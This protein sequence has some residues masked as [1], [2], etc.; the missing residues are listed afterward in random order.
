[1]GEPVQTAE[2]E[3]EQEAQTA[4]TAEQPA[5]EAEAAVDQQA[6]QEPEPQDVVFTLPG[7]KK[8]TKAELI[9][10]EKLLSNLVTHSNQL[11]NFQ[12]LA[13]ERKAKLEQVEA[14]NRRVL[15]EYTRWQMQQQAQQQAQQMQQ[16][17]PQRPPAQVI[18]G[19]FAPVLDQ[20]VQDGRLSQDHRTEFGPLIA[21]YLFDHQNLRNMVA[22]VIQAGQQEFQNLRQTLDGDV[23]PNVQQFRVQQATA[24]DQQV[25]QE[26]AT[27]PGYEGLAD[28]N[29]WNRLKAFISEKVNASPRLENGRPSFDPQFDPITMA[30][31]YDA[32]T[33]A[34]L[35]QQIATEKARQQQASQQT[36]SMVGGEAA[37][38][39]GGPVPKKPG[40]LTPEE[41][42]MDFGSPNMMTG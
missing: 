36:R 31:M 27:I 8:V 40:K 10:D 32:M 33:G 24:L 15:D 3:P 4:E 38:R 37:A 19:H 18:E 9:A 7:G 26:I 41:E 5:V 34:E 13:E 35:R 12:R 21:E 30:Q 29:E 17:Q 14:E 39:A 25:Q 6:A 20:M 2:P 23:V 1:M 11:T 22:S 28:P 42:A 16:P